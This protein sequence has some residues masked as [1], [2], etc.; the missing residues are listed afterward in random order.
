MAILRS[1]AFGTDDYICDVLENSM[2]GLPK[3]FRE[4]GNRK[5]NIF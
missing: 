1:Q 5:E 2:I 3:K 4:L